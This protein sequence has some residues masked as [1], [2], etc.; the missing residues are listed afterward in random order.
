M[1]MWKHTTPHHRPNLSE[2]GLRSHFSL[3]ILIGFDELCLE[4]LRPEDI[5]S[6]LRTP[7]PCKS[8]NMGAPG[9]GADGAEGHGKCICSFQRCDAMPRSSNYKSAFK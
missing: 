7:L 2:M 3:Q 8:H 9:K 1:S 6:M 5:L 4:K